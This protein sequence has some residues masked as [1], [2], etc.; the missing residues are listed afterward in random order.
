MKVLIIGG[1]GFIGINGAQ[2]F[3]NDGHDVTILDNFSRNGSRVNASWLAEL[4][5]SVNI[6]HA[7]VRSDHAALRSSMKKVDLVLHEA[8]QV[9]VTTSVADPRADFEINALGTF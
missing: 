8:A 9:A 4:Y 2:A 3:L 5:P 7:D 6:V 1:A